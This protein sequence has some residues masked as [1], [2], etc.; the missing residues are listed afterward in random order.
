M[1]RIIITPTFR[2]HFAFNRDFLES[3]RQNAMDADE[4]EIHFVVADDERAD[5]EAVL[6]EF[7]DIGT[8][9]HSFEDLLRA[10]G[11]ETTSQELLKEV[12]K[13]AFQ[14]LKKLYALKELE[15]DQALVLDSES[16]LLK[17]ARVGAA[18]DKYFADPFVVFSDL[19]HR[20]DHWFGLLGD[21][22]HQNVAR[23]LG[24]T[25]PKMYLLEYYGWF[26][27]RHI[28]D[29]LFATLPSDLLM[30]VRQRLGKQKHIFECSLYYLY[31]FKN[32][33]RYG[34]RFVSANALLRRYLGDD[35]YR[36]YIANFTGAWERVGMFEF[37]SKEVNDE[38]L[39]GLLR[40]FNDLDLQFYRSEL[41]NHNER[42]QEALIDASQ[43][44]FLVSSESYRRIRERIAVCVGGPQRDYRRN[45]KHL[46]DFLGDSN[47]DIFCHLWDAPD[48]DVVLQTLEPMAYEEDDDARMAAVIAG[49]DLSTA[50]RER[51]VD[52][53]RDAAAIAGFYSTWRANELKRAHERAEGFTYD[54]VVNITAPLLA[55]QDLAA[56]IDSIRGRQRG[57]DRTLYVPATMQGTGVDGQ[58]AIGSSSTMDLVAGLFGRLEDLADHSLF[59]PPHLLLRHV[60]EEGL[61]IQVF[62]IDQ[63]TLVA[64]DQP[65]DLDGLHQQLEHALTC[66]SARQLPP[67]LPTMVTEYFEAKALSVACVAE[68][69]LETPR[70][71][72]LL[73][74]GG[75][76]LRVEPSGALGF[77]VDEGGAD[78]FLLVVAG[79]VDRTAV[80]LRARQ[81]VE[82]DGKR[83]NVYAD[84]RLALRA[85]GPASREA[86]FFVSRVDGGIG[87]E[88]RSGFFLVDDRGPERDPQ[89]LWLAAG[90]IGPALVP[91]PIPIAGERV[92]DPT[93][94]ALPMG[95]RVEVSTAEPTPDDARLTR[96]T[97]RIYTAARVFEARGLS[98]LTTDSKVF[99]RKLHHRPSQNS[100]SSGLRALA[101]KVTAR[102]RT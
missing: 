43:I 44:T 74:P 94:E 85:A 54:V 100:E 50:R 88:W 37:V 87:L 76:Y 12:E 38:N 17:P 98:G 92:P 49:V 30:L 46:R 86:A 27:D 67:I 59:S 32:Q 11:H 18:F 14:S 31:L 55:L 19:S 70:A 29:D 40:L 66:W 48:R 52:A 58:L 78:L 15:Y 82:T 47:V 33:E 60:L 56:A 3:F 77:A 89:R 42:A 34:Y 8:T 81:L 73:V 91:A 53:D 6:A 95:L 61:E 36:R 41:V 13:F 7:P 65:L 96:W 21:V 45:L 63:V 2:P 62:A 28:V 39:P 16:L 1:R 69:E 97:W 22:V 10:N 83:S 35:G 71:F 80:N 72:R 101:N 4:I 5:L 68:L 84:R 25:C 79:D 90:P 24:V 102:V 99:I 93:A 51:F 75:G 57:F 9:V 23:L 64:E 26:Y 20:N